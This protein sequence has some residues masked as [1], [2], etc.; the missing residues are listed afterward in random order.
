MQEAITNIVGLFGANGENFI[1]QFTIYYL[2]SYAIILVIGIIGAT[3]IPRNIIQKLQQKSKLKKII[4]TLEPVYIVILLV[5]V[6]AYLV[7]NSYNPFLYFR[8]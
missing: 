1:N 3:P 7:D 2:K 4:N 8:F 5:I 6:T